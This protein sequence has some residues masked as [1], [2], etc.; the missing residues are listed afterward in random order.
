ME[1]KRFGAFSSSV[2]P[3]KLALT[4]SGALKLITGIAVYYGVVQQIDADSLIA[5]VTS[6]ITIAWTAYG[7]LQ[8]ITGILRKI[9]VFFS[10]K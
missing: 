5:A 10:K 2:D 1:Y 9:V 3:Q 4:I 6:L 7:L 8:T